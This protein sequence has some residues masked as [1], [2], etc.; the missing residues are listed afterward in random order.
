MLAIARRKCP[1]CEVE[2]DQSW[3]CPVCSES[4]ALACVTVTCEA[5]GQ[6]RQDQF[7]GDKLLWRGA[8]DCTRSPEEIRARKAESLAKEKERLTELAELERARAAAEELQRQEGLLKLKLPEH[9][10]VAQGCWELSRQACRRDPA[11][12]F[13]FCHACPGFRG[14]G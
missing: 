2:L 4:H 6:P 12:F 8:C 7:N 10:P 13:E 9:R 11:H 1:T 14:R 5:C 3:R